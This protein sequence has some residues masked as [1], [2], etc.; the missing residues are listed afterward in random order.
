M[1]Q[2]PSP[3]EE[4]LDGWQTD[5]L[6][7]FGHLTNFFGDLHRA[8]LPYAHAAEMGALDQLKSRL[9]DYLNSVGADEPKPQ[10]KEKR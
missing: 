8:V 3:T 2:A 6:F 5:K 7:V 1:N 4:L 10:Q 9:L